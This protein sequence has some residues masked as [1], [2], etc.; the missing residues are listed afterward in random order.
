MTDYNDNYKNTDLASLSYIANNYKFTN[1]SVHEHVQCRQ[2]TKFLAHEIK[3]FHSIQNNWVQMLDNQH[4]TVTHKVFE[5]VS[6]A[7]KMSEDVTASER[8]V[9]YQA[10]ICRIACITGQDFCHE[11][12]TCNYRNITLVLFN[13]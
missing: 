11:G 10:E 7:N 12:Q 9:T 13:N 1:S 4:K 2:A 8:S 5:P 3:I 6:V